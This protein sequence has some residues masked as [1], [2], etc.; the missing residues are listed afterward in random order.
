MHQFTQAATPFSQVFNRMEKNL[1]YNHLQSKML[2]P[3]LYNLQQ[4]V[5]KQQ[6]A[7]KLCFAQGSQYN[8]LPVR[9]HPTFGIRQH[10]TMQM[11]KGPFLF[12][13]QKPRLMMK[14]KE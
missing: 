1:N 2:L 7:L 11:I 5:M 9:G 4:T 14:E 13:S 8:S 12:N 3:M 6:M 10:E